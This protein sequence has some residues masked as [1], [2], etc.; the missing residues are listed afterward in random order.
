MGVFNIKNINFCC[1][2]LM[3]SAAANRMCHV[4]SPRLIQSE[5]WGRVL[6]TLSF[7]VTRLADSTKETGSLFVFKLFIFLALSLMTCKA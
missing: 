1:G 6:V 3:T 5:P 7:T 4:T 2:V